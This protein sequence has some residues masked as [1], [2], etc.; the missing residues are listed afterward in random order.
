MALKSKEARVICRLNH[1][2]D[3][4]DEMIEIGLLRR[5]LS[6][7]VAVRLGGKGKCLCQS[8]KI[9]DHEAPHSGRQISLHRSSILNVELLSMKFANLWACPAN[10]TGFAGPFMLATASF[11]PDIF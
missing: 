6:S 1:K 3:N 8:T 2:I 4:F 7:L 9:S 10:P 5:A 11:L